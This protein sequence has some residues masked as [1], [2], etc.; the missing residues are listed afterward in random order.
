MMQKAQ[1][2]AKVLISQTKTEHMYAEL[3][4]ASKCVLERGIENETGSSWQF[5]SSIVLTAFSLEAYVN[6]VGE[7][8]PIRWQDHER[9]PPL[10]KLQ[11]V[12]AKLKVQIQK[13]RRPFQTLQQL[14]D[15]RNA[16]AHGRTKTIEGRPFIYDVDRA[17]A[18]LG[19]RFL[20]D[21][22][23]LI[24]TKEFAERAR[25]DVNRIVAEIHDARTDAKEDLFAFGLGFSS[26]S[27]IETDPSVR[28]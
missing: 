1:P 15:F 4:H 27:L 18:R 24:Q 25:A 5:L 17:D 26:A 6:H 14:Q 20:A 11:L 22:E 21:W 9:L 12:C 7:R 28:L 3:W 19:Q 23:K 8:L 10:N 2:S 13:G 16:M